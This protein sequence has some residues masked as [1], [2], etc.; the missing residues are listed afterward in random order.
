MD[1]VCYR[2]GDY[3]YTVD[4]REGYT[5]IELLV[6]L[7]I[8][9][10]MAGIALANNNKFGRQVDLENNAYK[11]ALDVRTAQAFGINRLDTDSGGTIQWELEF[12]P[13]QPYGIVFSSEVAANTIPG[14]FNESYAIFLDRSDGSFRENFFDSDNNGSSA[15]CISNTSSECVDIISINRGV[16]ISDICVRENG[17]GCAA[18]VDQVH[19]SFQRPNPDAFIR[20]PNNTTEYSSAEI[21]LTSPI[22]GIA[23]QKI[24]VGSAGQVAIE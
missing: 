2:C 10:I 13:P 19:I 16:Y 23:D 7:A 4:M 18:G 22:A 1:C 20:V 3:R 17:G 5:L 11:L 21:T 24:F 12:A 15:T 6:V 9:F 14:V 8:I